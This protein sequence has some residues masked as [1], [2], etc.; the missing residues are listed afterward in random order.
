[1]RSNRTAIQFLRL[2][3][4]PMH[5]RDAMEELESKDKRICYY[6]GTDT[7]YTYYVKNSIRYQWYNLKNNICCSKCYNKLVNSP[8]W[9]EIRNRIY[10]P[11]HIYFKGKPF[12]LPIEPRK[13]ICSWCKRKKGDEFIRSDGK[14]AKIRTHMHHIE[15]HD[16]DI[17]KDTI[18]LCQ[19]CHT[20][21][22]WK[23]GS[24]N[25]DAYRNKPSRWTKKC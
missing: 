23:L 7:T 19:V 2:Y 8:K 16:D 4:H 3:S 22:S 13:G 5:C 12:I 9:Q 25:T 6:C 14:P 15:Y 20:K 1:M 18:E 17:L 21:E 11:R 24:F 10:N